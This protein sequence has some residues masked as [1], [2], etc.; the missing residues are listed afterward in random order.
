MSDGRM[1]RMLNVLDEFTQPRTLHLGSSGFTF[2]PR[3][4]FL[5]VKLPQLGLEPPEPPTV[6]E[7]SIG[8]PWGACP[9]WG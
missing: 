3:P 6:A 8:P 1:Y 5:S 9:L 2:P 7:R 4:P